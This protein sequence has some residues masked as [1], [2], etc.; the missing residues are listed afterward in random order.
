MM[1]GIFLVSASGFAFTI[2]RAKNG[3]K[4]HWEEDPTYYI[5]PDSITSETAQKC[6]SDPIATI[7]SALETWLSIPN[8]SISAS[9]GGTSEIIYFCG[10]VIG[11]ETGCDGVNLI[12]FS[13]SSI[14]VPGTLALTVNKYNPATGEIIETDI[15]INDKVSWSDD[16]T[17]SL[18]DGCTG[19][20]I[21]AFPA[22]ITHELGHFLGLDHSFLGW[23]GPP[24]NTVYADIAPTMFPFY[25]RDYWEYA[26]SLE[27]DDKAGLVY[28]YPGSAPT[29]FGNI[30][31]RVKLD[32]GEGLFG[33]HIVAL[34]EN[35][36][37]PIID[38][39]SE[40][41]GNYLVYGLPPENYYVYAESPELSGRS[42]S[43]L[44]VQTGYWDNPDEA[45]YVQLY[46]Q[47]KVEDY[48]QLTD[49]GTVFERAEVKAVSVSDGATTSGVDFIYPSSGDDGGC[50][51]M[52][53]PGKEFG[54]DIGTGLIL[55]LILGLGLRALTKKRAG[56]KL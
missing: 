49:G 17:G 43:E 45:P 31:G 13:Q 40:P 30:S 22:V 33:V 12:V 46:E 4:I 20:N 23:F 42:I 37:A 16:P 50:G 14:F 38:T 39:V 32:T 1:L 53:I 3:A 15:G 52:L 28:L 56:I 18:I 44:L 35:D 9:Y 11:G 5:N 48:S 36:K 51:C 25:F 34:K 27:Q 54:L 24:V 10:E 47:V 41:N 6:I 26:T 7:R 8:I 29:G 55:V 21:Y 2:L 19:D